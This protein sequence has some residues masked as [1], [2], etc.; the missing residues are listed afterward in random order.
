MKIALAGSVGLSRRTLEAL[1]RHGADVAGVLGLAESESRLVSGYA[2]MDEVAARAG[3]PYRDFAKLN[4]PEIVEQLEAWAPDVLFVVGIS[5]M[6]GESVMRTARLG[7]VGFHP[8]RLPKGRGRAPIA[9]IV[10]DGVPAAATY[11]Q[12]TDQPD[13]G[14][15]FVQEPVEVGTDD[16]AAE[17][18]RK[19]EDA[20]DVALDRW[21]PSLL[22]GRWEPVAQDDAEATFYAIRR[23]NDGLIRWSDPARD[24][25]RL[26][27]ASAHPHPGAFTF[28]QGRRLIVWRASVVD[29]PIRGVVGRVVDLADGQPVVQTGTGLLRLESY[30]WS[31]EQDVQPELRIG[32]LLGMVPELKWEELSHRI[33]ALEARL[34]Q[35]KTESPE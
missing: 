22:A 11:F 12:L 21:L 9:W 31:D 23:P 30:A 13:A 7:C 1:V 15:I 32:T 28:L 18:I 34:D 6:A 14:G 4:A 26:V 25:H 2:R 29:A 3:I 27:R 16:D 35:S 5:Q 19:I 24:I 17:V 8:T 10:L 20:A 33:A